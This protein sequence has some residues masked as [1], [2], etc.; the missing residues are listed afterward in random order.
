MPSLQVS[1]SSHESLS[2]HSAGTHTPLWQLSS[3]WQPV[4]SVQG[5]T[6]SPETH[7]SPVAQSSSV[8]QP[9]GVQPPSAVQPP[10]PTEKGRQLPAKQV[11]PAPQSS[12]VEHSLLQPVASSPAEKT[13]P[14]IQV[15]MGGTLPENRLQVG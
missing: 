13:S 4:R 1:P 5:A 2:S 12:L 9:S 10:S 8:V 7:C 6:Q 3:G 15:R 11:L 14:S